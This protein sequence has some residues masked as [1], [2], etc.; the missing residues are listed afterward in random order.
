MLKCGDRVKA[1]DKSR[2]RQYLPLIATVMQISENEI[3]LSFDHCIN[4]IISGYTESEVSPLHND[5]P[6]WYKKDEKP[7]RLQSRDS[8]IS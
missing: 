8:G 4:K 6:N 1:V 7:I 3:G 2:S 5:R